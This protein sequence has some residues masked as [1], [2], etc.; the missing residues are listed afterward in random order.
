MCQFVF[1]SLKCCVWLFPFVQSCFRLCQVVLGYSSCLRSIWCLK[2]YRIVD[3]RFVVS[4]FS[5][6]IYVVFSFFQLSELFLRC[7]KFSRLIRTL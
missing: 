2:L 7:S 1:G 3:V 4:L 6:G 5:I